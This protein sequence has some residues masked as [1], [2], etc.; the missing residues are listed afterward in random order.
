MPIINQ[1]LHLRRFALSECFLVS[2]FDR[3]VRIKMTLKTTAIVGMLP[4]GNNQNISRSAAFLCIP[5]VQTSSQRSFVQFSTLNGVVTSGW[6][7]YRVRYNC[8]FGRMFV[9]V[10]AFDGG[11]LHLYHPALECR[12]QSMICYGLIWDEASVKLRQLKPLS[13]ALRHDFAD[14]NVIDLRQYVTCMCTSNNQ[15]GTDLVVSFF[16]W[17][18]LGDYVR[19]C[20]CF[21]APIICIR[22]LFS[23]II[24]ICALIVLSF[25]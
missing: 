4:V 22:R 10:R 12:Q 8:L 11:K 3:L 6:T 9:C 13:T 14:V 2:A 23:A 19:Y 21:S 18:D 20:R 17:K 25:L 24:I 16:V 1:Y 7:I 5:Y 15:F